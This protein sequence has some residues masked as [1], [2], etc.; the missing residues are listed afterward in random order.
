LSDQG[1]T[2]AGVSDRETRENAA[3]RRCRHP[4]TAPTPYDDKI[5]G[6][7]WRA[8][9]DPQVPD[10]I[11]PVGALLDRHRGTTIDSKPPSSLREQPSATASCG[12][13]CGNM[14]GH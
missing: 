6:A 13:S 4:L 5:Y 1:K 8:W 12:T 2:T 14:P 7:E 10:W 9:R 11:D 3:M